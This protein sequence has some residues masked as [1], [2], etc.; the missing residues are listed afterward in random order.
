MPLEFIPMVEAD[1]TFFIEVHHQAYR[2][3]I[4]NMFGWDEA[5]Q[6]IMASKSFDEGG[7]HSILKENQKI[8]VIG[9]EL[10]PDYFWLKNLFILPD[11]QNQGFGTLILETC[12]QKAK[13]S[14]KELR[15]Q[16]LKANL[17]AK[18]LYE[19]HGFKVSEATDTHWKMYLPF[20][21]IT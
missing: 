13:A 15:L 5:F 9:W 8:G 19:R 12:I 4:E 11:Y 1:R 18:A 6:D 17:R 21:S 7:H 2:E 3:T 10:R 14:V 16:T 20:S